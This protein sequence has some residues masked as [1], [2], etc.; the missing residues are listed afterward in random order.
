ME[1]HAEWSAI[2]SAS[3]VVKLLGLIQTSMTQQQTRQ[4]SEHAL[5]E[6]ELQMYL[7]KQGKH[8]SNHDYY[9]RFKDNVTTVEQLGGEVGT[10]AA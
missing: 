2:D 4:Y 9:E 5:I 3:D 7:F 8:M 10:H 6:A 1:A